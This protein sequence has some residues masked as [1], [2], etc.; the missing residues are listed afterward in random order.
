MTPWA[1]ELAMGGA[2]IKFKVHQGYRG[3]KGAKESDS[4][5]DRGVLDS[6]LLSS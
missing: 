3:Y 4:V 1:V 6:G 5:A 2:L